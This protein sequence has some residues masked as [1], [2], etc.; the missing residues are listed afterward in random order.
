M[1]Q[2]YESCMLC[3][4][5]CGVDRT[6]GMRGRCG[7]GADVTLARAARHMWEEPC[8]SGTRGSGTVFFSGCPLGCV[9]CQNREI[10]LG[11]NG[12]PV[13]ERRLTEIFWELCGAGVHNVNLVTAT[14]FTPTVVRAIRTVKEAGFSL[15]FVWNTSGYERPETL[16]ML[17]GLIDVYLTDA[18]YALPRT[19][20]HYSG[21][22]DYPAVADAAIREMVRQ[23]GAFQMGEDGLMRRGTVIR[24]LLLP[25]A[26]AEARLI[27]RRMY[28]IFGDRVYFSLMSQYTPMPGMTPPLDRRVTAHEYAGL[29]R[30]AERLGVTN[31]YIQT[32]ESAQESFIPPFD[33]TGI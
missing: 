24:I 28:R 16:R 7:A 25:G 22:P 5:M 33:H 20:A 21:A 26:G 6:H 4:R 10:A 27:L 11:H 19:A 14:H 2:P 9:Y 32:G 23:S 13:S 29:V 17:D 18:R 15:P 30:E 8:L 31:A 1:N 12:I 3:P